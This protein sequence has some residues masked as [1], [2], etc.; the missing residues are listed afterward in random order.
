MTT[1]TEAQQDAVEAVHQSIEHLAAT[2]AD[3]FLQ[4]RP[5]RQTAQIAMDKAELDCIA[6][7]SVYLAKAIV[8]RV[9]SRKGI[10]ITFDEPK[11]N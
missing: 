6:D 2:Y 8:Q 10:T 7:S 5:K 1:L 4:T 9:A 3:T 11:R